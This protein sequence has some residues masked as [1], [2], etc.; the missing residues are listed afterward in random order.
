MEVSG[1]L[2][3]RA[4][5]SRVLKITLVSFRYKTRFR[6]L[7]LVPST[8]NNLDHTL[9]ISFFSSRVIHAGYEIMFLSSVG[10]IN[11]SVNGSGTSI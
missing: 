10:S 5:L 4:D 8:G 7:A 6:R 3:T 2:H 9:M 1:K 11:I